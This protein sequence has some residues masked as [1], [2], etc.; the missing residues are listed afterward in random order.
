VPVG[1]GNVVPAE[2]V[3]DKTVHC[4]Y[5]RT[6]RTTGFTVLRFEPDYGKVGVSSAGDLAMSHLTLQEV[7]E[8][9]TKADSPETDQ[10]TKIIG[11]PRYPEFYIPRIKVLPSRLISM[12]RRRTRAKSY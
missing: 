6:S 7:I 3:D 9:I 11:Q 2:V 8:R 4:R 5:N 10:R 12:L 1:L